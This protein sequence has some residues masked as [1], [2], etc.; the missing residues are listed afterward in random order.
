MRR[1]TCGDCKN[2]DVP[3]R[4]MTTPEGFWRAEHFALTDYTFDT[5]GTRRGRPAATTQLSKAE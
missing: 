5:V 4:A 3:L 2:G 1:Y